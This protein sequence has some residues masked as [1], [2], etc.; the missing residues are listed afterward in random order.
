MQ[1]GERLYAIQGEPDIV[2]RNFRITE[3]YADLSLAMSAL[4]GDGDANWLT[5]GLWASRTAGAFIRGEAT[6]VDWGR[7]AV[8]AGN[9]AII[10]DIAPCFIAYLGSC[11]PVPQDLSHPVAQAGLARIRE[12]PHLQNA[13]DKYERARQ[14]QANPS[15]AIRAQQIL[16]ANIHIAYHEQALA[17]RFVD[18]AIPLGGGF[19]IVATRFVTLLLP[20][21]EL[22]LGRPL[23]PPAYLNG[24]QWP[25][26]L[27]ELDDPDLQELYAAFKHTPHDVQASAA[28]SWEDFDERMGYIA[29]FFRAYQRDPALIPVSISK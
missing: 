6:W 23:E 25:E 19:G 12:F 8:A 7:E 3:M 28:R 11:S 16:S 10:E 9:L 13:F 17:D 26:V 5:F 4:L 21:T 2:T 20:H 18:A 1:W 15:D 27:D 22:H 24:R 14:R 29:T